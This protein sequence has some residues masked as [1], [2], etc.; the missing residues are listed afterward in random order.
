MW[1][2]FYNKTI[3]QHLFKTGG[4]SIYNAFSEYRQ[5][6]Q[7]MLVNWCSDKSYIA[8]Y[9]ILPMDVGN[10][11][12]TFD[13]FHV[14][15]PKIN[16]NEYYKFAFIRNTYDALVAGYKYSMQQSYYANLPEELRVPSA[17]AYTFEQH[18]KSAWGYDHTQWDF[19]TFKGEF[20]MD[21]VGRFENLQED[22]NKVCTHIGLP[23]HTL[24]KLNVSDTHSYMLPEI[25][26]KAKQHYSLWYTDEIIEFVTKKAKAEIDYFGFKFEDKR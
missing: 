20:I 14:I 21:F 6:D 3:F 16:F 4:H 2:D 26:E 13:Q 17:K 18:V 19:L 7:H 1:F 5:V 23:I 22:F 25:T 15:Y 12:I 9:N 24:P 10:S 11:H 8:P